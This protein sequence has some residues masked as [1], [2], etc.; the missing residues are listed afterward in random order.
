MF[1]HFATTKRTVEEFITEETQSVS[2]KP[3]LSHLIFRYKYATGIFAS[4]ENG[5]YNVN[6]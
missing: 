2:S 6:A 5:P 1:H 4:R 3:M